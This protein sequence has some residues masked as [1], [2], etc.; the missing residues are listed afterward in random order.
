MSQEVPRQSG[1]VTYNLYFSGYRNLEVAPAGY[2][3][4]NYFDNKK[5]LIGVEDALGGVT[6][7]FYDGQNHLTEVIDPR[8]NTTLYQYDGDNNLTRVIDAYNRETVNT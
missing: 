8:D 3:T 2:Q 6:E 4:I 5:R 1:P 7:K